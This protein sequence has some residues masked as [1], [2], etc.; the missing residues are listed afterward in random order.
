MIDT[1]TDQQPPSLGTEQGIRAAWQEHGPLLRA[2]AVRRLR[3]RELAEDVLQE[4]FLRAWR[5][6]DRFDAQRGAVRTW[7]FA[8][9]CNLCGAE[10][11]RRS[12]QEEAARLWNRRTQA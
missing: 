4:T 7:L 12:T 11:P 5:K 1:R 8:I 6:A 10:G 9:M 3:D 2:F